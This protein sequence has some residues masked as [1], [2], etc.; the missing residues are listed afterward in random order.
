MYLK[1][2]KW[3]HPLFILRE[4]AMLAYILFLETSTLKVIPELFRQIPRA[5]K[6]RKFIFS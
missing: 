6:K 3:Y 2:A 1:N 4:I 5:M